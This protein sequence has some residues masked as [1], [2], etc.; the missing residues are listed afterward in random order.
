MNQSTLL[1]LLIALATATFLPPPTSALAQDIPISSAQAAVMEDQQ[2]SVSDEAI[3][4]S[5][6]MQDQS[7]AAI[8]VP[9]NLYTLTAIWLSVKEP[10]VVE[11][12]VQLGDN[13]NVGQTIAE[14]DQELPRA[15][16]NAAEKELAIARI[17]S[18]NDV[19]LRFA[20]V[21]SKVNQAV[22]ERSMAAN[23][24]YKKA[25]SKTEIE[26][27]RLE[28]ERSHLSA[29]QAERTKQ[30]NLLN[31]QLKSEQVA[32]AEI[33]LS[34]RTISAPISGVVTEVNIEQGEWVNAG[35]PI[36]RIVNIDTLRFTGFVDSREI[37]PSEIAKSAS[38]IVDY[39]GDMGRRDSAVDSSDAVD[40]TITFINPEI[41]P[42]SG[43]YEIRAEVDNRDH[44][45]YS[46]LKSILKLRREN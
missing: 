40:V 15:Q 1:P 37:L 43:L 27:L 7:S 44:R 26:R 17:E 21:S 34:N 30:T 20:R 45:M 25:L 36:A 28:L 9:G 13:V 42:A 3:V 10:G 8:T 6:E 4:S 31:E 11:S 24:Q 46:G 29:E 35:Q 2:S 32:I 33:Q 23:R 39:K 22:L 16:M 19:D 5:D 14:L 41:D 12:I 38:L 18:K